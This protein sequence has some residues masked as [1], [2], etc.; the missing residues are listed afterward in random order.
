MERQEFDPAIIYE[1]SIL[2]HQSVS[3]VLKFCGNVVPQTETHRLPSSRIGLS[4]AR[5]AV[6][7]Q[8]GSGRRFDRGCFC[9]G[10]WLRF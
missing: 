2:G 3:V 6:E 10:I 1:P 9:H 8:V 5:R 7:D 4:G